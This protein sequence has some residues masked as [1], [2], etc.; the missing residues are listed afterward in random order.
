MASVSQDITELARPEDLAN[1]QDLYGTRNGILFVVDATPPMFIKDEDQETSYFVESIR[2]YKEI[3]MQKLV[4]NRQDWMGLVLFGIEKGDQDTE[5]KNILTLQK[6]NIPS[7]SSLQ[8]MIEIDDEGRWEEY[9]D[10]ACTN[11]YPLHDVLWHAARVFCSVRVTM[12]VKKV[13]LLTC[14]D[15]PPMT[16]DNEKRRIVAKAKSYSDLGLKLSI[17]GLGEDWNH[18]LFYKDLE[19][20]SGKI[21]TENCKRTSLVDLMQ[22]IKLPS[23]SMAKL[24]WRLGKNVIIDVN[25]RSL[26]VKRETLKKVYVSKESNK[27]LTS[28]RYLKTVDNEMFED[29]NFKEPTLPHVL[30]IN[31]RKYKQYGGKKIYFTLPEVN[32]LC[33]V[34]EPGIDLICAKPISYHPLY[35]LG[36]P[37]FVAPAKSNRKD[38]TLLFAA[39]IDK[40]KSKNLMMICAVTFRKRSSPLLYRMIPNAEKGGFYLLK[41]PFREYVRD[42]ESVSLQYMYDNDTNKPPTESH[43]IKLLEKI[44]KKIRIHY[45]PSAFYNPKVQAQ[46]QML[47]T[48]ALDWEKPEPILDDT[49]PRIEEMQGLTKDL[50]TQYNEI[51]D[52]ETMCKTE[53]P[54]KKKV[55][56]ESDIEDAALLDKEAIRKLAQKGQLSSK[57]VPELKVM[58]KN[59]GLT[60]SGKKNDLIQRIKQYY[61]S[62][63]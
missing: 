15:N 45:D 54:A 21:D 14:Q 5:M 25:L 42:L 11:V 7:K 1:T 63:C 18:D 49:L 24:P 40:C 61:K 19:I 46:I 36:K 12:L 32:T 26:V 17:V 38:N 44:M 59:I 39:L 35:H 34:C 47:Q 22:Q 56:K 9:K 4:W 2:L 37:Y 23:R 43:E 3:L 41:I 58:C 50:L 51:F 28:H 10:I 55:K 30:D 29:D 60:V 48:V 13:I 8:Q 62:E 16:N 33:S 53:E 57:T 20:S 6:L 27:P 52:T 31:I